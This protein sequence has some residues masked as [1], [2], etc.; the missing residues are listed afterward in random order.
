MNQLKY[1]ILVLSL[2]ACAVNTTLGNESKQ[3]FFTHIIFAPLLN[4]ISANGQISSSISKVLRGSETKS[5][6]MMMVLQK[7]PE[8]EN[9][10][11]I[12][13]P[14]VKGIKLIAFM[15]GDNIEKIVRYNNNKEEVF[16]RIT[17]RFLTP[18]AISSPHA[19]FSLKQYLELYRQEEFK[20]LFQKSRMEIPV[21]VFS[22]RKDG[23]DITALFK[24]QTENYFRAVKYC[25]DQ[26]LES[27]HLMMFNQK[28]W[29]RLVAHFYRFRD[30]WF[31]G[32]SCTLNSDR[33]GNY[34][35]Y[36]QN[37]LVKSY[38]ESL[39]GKWG[40]Q[41]VWFRDGSFEAEYPYPPGKP[42]HKV[43]SVLNPNFL[44]N[45]PE[46]SQWNLEDSLFWDKSTQSPYYEGALRFFEQPGIFPITLYFST[47]Q[48]ILKQKFLEL[49]TK[50]SSSSVIE[51]AKIGEDRFLFQS[52]DKSSYGIGVINQNMIFLLSGADVKTI[53]K[54]AI[55]IDQAYLKYYHNSVKESH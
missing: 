43:E 8:D 17:E 45:I 28:P 25:G 42:K 54:I 38:V 35:E 51:V 32:D 14:A 10:I 11:E 12:S 7:M 30:S 47:N 41:K 34:I 1:L 6:S 5:I 26:I 2:L 21:E 4:S 36:Y 37:G 16:S 23:G 9:K 55:D 22:F 18:D 49:Q 24:V 13:F 33:T 19:D 20:L 53:E 50:L 52:A 44:Q 31:L 46:F 40:K 15:K 48:D 29:L 39:H 3:L 27:G